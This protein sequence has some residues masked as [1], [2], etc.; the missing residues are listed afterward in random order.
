MHETNIFVLLARGRI[1]LTVPVAHMP[2]I[3]AYER[4][5]SQQSARGIQAETMKYAD[6][7]YTILRKM[8]TVGTENK[9]VAK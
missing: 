9:G 1:D 4:R 3:K 7:K 6:G 2:V 8:A 5:G